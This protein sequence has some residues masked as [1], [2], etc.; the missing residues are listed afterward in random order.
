VE[1]ILVDIFE[2]RTVVQEKDNHK[3]II[4]QIE[5]DTIK[6]HSADERGIL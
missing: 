4:R 3:N 6:R 5:S 1:I 2:R